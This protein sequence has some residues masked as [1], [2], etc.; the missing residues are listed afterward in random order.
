MAGTIR[1]S[2]DTSSGPSE[3]SFLSQ[4]A[5]PSGRTA[6]TDA[7]TSAAGGDDLGEIDPLRRAGR[8]AVPE[9]GA[10]TPAPAVAFDDEARQK[11][12]A[13]KPGFGRKVERTT[14]LS[15]STSPKKLRDTAD[16][17]VRVTQGLGGVVERSNVD[18]TDT[19][20]SASFELSIPTARLDD[21]IAQL[22]KLAHVSSMNQ[23][24]TDITRSFVSAAD[25]LSDAR[26]E[27]K[28]LLKAL[29]AARTPERIATLRARLRL[30]RSEIANHNGQLQSLRR[31][32]D[33]TKV[34]VT[35]TGDGTAAATTDDGWSFGGAADD[36]VRVLEVIASI[37]LIS[38]AVLVPLGLIAALAVIAARVSTRRRRE[39]AL[40]A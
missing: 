34:S 22:S 27:R 25:K 15:L 4:S 28:A 31:R 26:A 33:N 36:A 30:N 14:D 18:S 8:P 17:V 35:L 39:Q 13:G 10:A 29:G 11:S 40:D 19:G 1:D 23:G 5:P 38:A 12:A 3:T 24:S 6:D 2:S 16:G 9:A 20:G 32:A 21:A 37:V 7:A